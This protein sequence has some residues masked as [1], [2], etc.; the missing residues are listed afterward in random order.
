[1]KLNLDWAN[2]QQHNRKIGLQFSMLNTGQKPY[3]G[4]YSAKTEALSSAIVQV[5]PRYFQR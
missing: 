1:M 3:E 2:T 4:K 5:D